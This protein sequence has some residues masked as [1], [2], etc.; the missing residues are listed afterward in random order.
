MNEQLIA[1][2]EA[3]DLERVEALLAA[4]ANPNATKGDETAY[5]LVPHGANEIKCALIEAGVEDPELRHA[6]VWVISTG[7][8]Q[9]VRTL[10]EKGADVN[11]STYS[12]SPIQVAARGGHNEI[13]ELLIAAGA[14]VDAGSSISTPLLDAIEREHTDIALQLIA[15]GAD[16]NRTA[17]FGGNQPI[18]LAAAQ[19]SV[20]LIQALIAAGANVNAKIPHITLNQSAVRQ[21]AASGLTAAFSAM[22]SLGQI[23][24]SLEDV[25]ADDEVPQ[26]RMVEIEQQ[27]SQIESTSTSQ[28]TRSIEPETTVDTFPVIVSARCGRAEAL[29]TL[30]EAGADPDCKDGEGLS[31][32]DW[33]VRNEYPD[34][35]AVLRRFGITQTRV[36]LDEKL[37]LAAEIGDLDIVRDCLSQGANVNVRDARRR[38]KDKSPLMLAAR[39]GH[40]AVV[41]A[42]LSANAD[43]NLIDRRDDERPVS[44]SLLAH[45]DPDTVMSMGSCLGRTALMS[46]A[47]TG[48]TEI[49]RALIQAGAN[50]NQQDDIEYTALALAVENSHLRAVRVLV[51]AGA[52]VNIAATYGNTPLI[53][54]C[55]KGS[56]EMA[57]FLLDRGANIA[58]TNRDR[59]TALMKAAATGSLPL[60]R[61]CI[62]RGAD[63]NT[64]S[65]GRNTALAIAAGASHNVRVDKNDRSS[66]SSI[67]EYRDDGSCW[68]WQPLPADRVI[69]VVRALLQA[70]AD[71]N[72]PN[73]ETTA[74]IEATRNDRLQ[75][76]Q[77][78][79]DGGAQLD[80]RDRDG[81]TAASIAKLYGRREILSFL[82]AYTGT[83]L[84][85][86]DNRNDDD[87]DDD[88]DL[89]DEDDE[90]YPRWGE[91]L[92]QPDFAAAV[93]N[94]DYQQAVADLA[95]LCGSKPTSND[96]APGWFS[97]HVESKRRNS[98]D[99]E[100]IQLQ[101]LER[102]YFV[103]EPRH[104]YGDGPEQLCILPTSDKYDV[105]ALH[106]TNG[107]NYGIG[108]GYVVQWLK[109][110]EA[111]QPFILTCIAHDTL[112]GRFLTPIEDPEGLA[113]RMYDFCSDIVDQ[114]CGEVAFLA[115]KL[116]DSDGL[117][118]W[119]D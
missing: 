29:A 84:S 22:E 101:F 73:G 74:A 35:L 87:N 30:L 113:E 1:A 97:T 91:D 70:G 102:G 42:L 20:E 65:K 33:A 8:V 68:E 116:A 3:K 71:P 44:K 21:Q 106:Q 62:D 50:P 107:C 14:D 46:V 115:E 57:E 5:Q 94:P 25:D 111:E 66:G 72:L 108:P 51:A 104:F 83:D 15:A 80:V 41:A 39:S 118:F 6:L 75:L 61:L 76:L 47:V 31:A 40:L 27:I 9:A 4:G 81:D 95:E 17:D 114:G 12:G 56:F 103:Y 67:R 2:I 112:A 64:V 58:T 105:I 19:G 60:V 13:L 98:I 24:T 26:E 18:S 82:Q 109:D 88:D 11:V 43:P 90:E 117:F 53:L 52:D 23:M 85:E 38:T 89:D 96:D 34:V 36:S 99:T 55:E 100:A 16:P 79:L 10:I 69:E 32:Y 49:I 54:A 78:L 48:S 7:R 77:I 59:E 37:L 63:V 110:L 93:S 92:P 28:T 45:T 119:W 86:F